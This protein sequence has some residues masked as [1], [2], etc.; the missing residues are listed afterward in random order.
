MPII[1]IY[2]EKCTRCRQCIKDCPTQDFSVEDKQEQIVFDGT[3]C[4]SCG[5]CIAVCPENAI[6]YSNNKK[7]F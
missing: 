2:V 7:L 5:H 3:R 1:G 4:I 6:E